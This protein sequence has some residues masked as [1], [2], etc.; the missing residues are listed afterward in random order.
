MAD[1]KMYYDKDA[2]LGLLKGKKIAVIGYGSQGHSQAQNLRDSGMDVV[3]GQR[4][5]SE[6]CKKCIADGFKPVSAA[7][8]TKGADWVHIL[9]PDETQAAVWTNDIKPNL[10][11]GATISFS[12][13]FNIRFN[14]IE[15]PKDANVVMI[16]PKGPGHLVRRQY[17]EGK[18]VPCLSRF[19]KTR[20]ATPKI[21]RFRS[22]KE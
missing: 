3:I 16:A 12:H 19:I 6:N 14:Q 22:L 20:P 9:L 21:L 17:V 5:G 15:P 7:E 1:A 8:A 13:G 4:E 2:D 18:G 11:K 10:K